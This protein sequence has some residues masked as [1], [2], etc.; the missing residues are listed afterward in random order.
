MIVNIFRITM[1][2]FLNKP[3]SISKGFFLNGGIYIMLCL[4]VLLIAASMPSFAETQWNVGVSGGDEDIRSFHLSIG[5]YYHVPEREV[6]V[7]HERGIYEEDLPVVFFIAQRAHVSPDAV[8]D[9]R[10]RGMNWMDITFHYGLSPEI[11]YVPVKQGPP[12]GH[13]YGYYQK[14]SKGGWHRD[15][16]E[17]ADIVNQVNLKFLSEHHKYAPEKVMEYRSEGKNFTIIDRDIRQG[18]QEK[19][20]GHGQEANNPDDY[21]HND[22]NQKDTNQGQGHDKGNGKKMKNN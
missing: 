17:D 16:L 15:D 6:I 18:E 13:A 19:T 8:V 12:Y 14:H 5:D 4:F 22:N 21:K 10:L 3:K 9:L 11:Y 1:N 20:H 2:E 7:V